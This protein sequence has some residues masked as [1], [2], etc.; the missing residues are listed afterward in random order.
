MGPHT[1]K[2]QEENFDLRECGGKFLKILAN[3]PLPPSVPVLCNL[4]S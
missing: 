4:L 2:L 3:D 1:Q